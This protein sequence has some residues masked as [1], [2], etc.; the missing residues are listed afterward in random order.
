MTAAPRTEAAVDPGQDAARVLARHNA[1]VAQLHVEALELLSKLVPMGE[2]FDFFAKKL[3]VFCGCDQVVYTDPDGRDFVWDAAGTRSMPYD[4]CRGCAFA[5]GRATVYDGGYVE[6]ADLTVPFR[7]CRVAT[8]CPVKSMAA[9]RVFVKGA[10]AGLVTVHYL[11]RPFTFSAEVREMFKHVVTFLGFVLERQQAEK[12]HAQ[13]LEALKRE[14]DRA[15]AAERAG[16]FFF[17]I[18]SHDIRTPLN[19]ILGYAELLDN[20]ISDACERHTAL[21]A[22]RTSGSTLL[23]LVNDVLDLSKL[24]AGRMDIL[25][26]PTDFRA[27]VEGVLECF[28]LTVANHNIAF[29]SHATELPWLGIDPQRFRQI[30]FNLVGNAAKFTTVGS[31][32][33][34]VAYADGVL[35]VDVA[36]TGCGIP[37]DMLP[38]IM[39][40]FIQVADAHHSGAREQGTGLG[41]SICRRMVERMGGTITVESEVGKGSVFKIRIPRV[42][43][44]AAP[45]E[46]SDADAAAVDV[47]HL[48]S[49][50]TLIVDDSKMNLLVLSAL[51]KKLGLTDVGTA[52]N[53]AQ[54]WTRLEDAYQA[55]TPY[56]VVLTDLWMP[57]MDGVELV[58]RIRADPRFSDLVVYVATADVEARKNA[59]A[60][61]FTGTLLK[62]ITLSALTEIFA[63]V[64]TGLAAGAR[65][66][67]DGL[68]AASKYYQWLRQGAAAMFANARQHAGLG[69][70][71]FE[72]DPD[73]E[74]RMYVDDTMR[75]LLGLKEQDGLTP[76][77]IYHAWFDRVDPDHLSEVGQG[78]ELMKQGRLAEIQYPWHH[79]TA[80]T[81]IVRCGGRRDF[82]YTRGVRIEGWHQNVTDLLHVQK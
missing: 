45:V 10:Y 8:G 66:P 65:K 14:R 4:V 11:R 19:A 57:D 54:A 55:G 13:T 72:L 12:E 34:Q 52:A 61:G 7:G 27:L 82:G 63:K 2:L 35:S 53:G 70:W 81:W 73:V 33:V 56:T 24:E 67:L 23:Q 32:T 15:L 29:L 68:S 31:V 6:L 5:D 40:P 28:R 75:D 3:L 80:G 79:P 20:G 37:A 76:E 18:V 50:R 62:P 51:L 16:N 17:S 41:L 26:V 9:Q 38:R 43:S 64:P 25:P 60:N 71:V 78:V 74:P 59:E 1:N 21:Q 42:E 22:I 77:Q 47:P 30:L 36:D 48:P 46:A 58:T 44:F 39:E 69:L 49:R